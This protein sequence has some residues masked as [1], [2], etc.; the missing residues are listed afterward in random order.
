MMV[1]RTFTF[2]HLLDFGS[3]ECIIFS[4]Q[5]KNKPKTEKPD[6]LTKSSYDFKGISS[7]ESEIVM[8]ITKEMKRILGE[9]SP[10]DHDVYGIRW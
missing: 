2:L 6:G 3:C 5:T 10:K 8:T 9:H 4:K 7:S 1:D